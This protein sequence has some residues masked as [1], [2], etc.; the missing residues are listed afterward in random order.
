[1]FSF[2]WLRQIHN[3]PAKLTFVVILLLCIVGVVIA[4]H[5]GNYEESVY[6]ARRWLSMTPSHKLC[7]DQNRPIHI[8]HDTDCSRYYEC[9]SGDAY[10]YSCAPGLLFN[11]Q[12]LI[13]ELASLVDCP[14]SDPVMHPIEIPGPPLPAHPNCSLLA[15]ALET[16]FWAHTTNCAK[17]YGCS[18]AGQILELQCPGGLVWHQHDKACA[19]PDPQKC[20]TSIPPAPTEQKADL[21]W[22]GKLQSWMG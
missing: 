6:C 3:L 22:W 7:R 18:E 20:C 9:A 17:Y 16:S 21:N 14:D 11:R 8:P 12:S 19:L 10:E 4:A 5:N 13:C 1:M 2:L 15:G